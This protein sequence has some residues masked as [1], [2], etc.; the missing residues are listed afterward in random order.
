MSA[1]AEHPI[2]HDVSDEL[3]DRFRADWDERHGP[4]VLV[5]RKG[6]HADDYRREGERQL[7]EHHAGDFKEDRLETLAIEPK[8]KVELPPFTT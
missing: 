5:I 3:V 7:R 1:V 8:V 4:S 2:E 6:G